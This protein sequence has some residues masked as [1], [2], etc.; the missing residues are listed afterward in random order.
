MCTAATGVGRG[1]SLPVSAQLWQGT[2]FSASTL[3]MAGTASTKAIW[4]AQARPRPVLR[5]C[6]LRVKL[7]AQREVIRTGLD[8]VVVA[9]S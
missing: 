3:I 6:E 5:P 9:R 1:R 7:G 8:R 2:G 4:D